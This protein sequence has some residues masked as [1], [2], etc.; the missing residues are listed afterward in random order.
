[1]EGLVSLRIILVSSSPS[2]GVI[3]QSAITIR[4]EGLK[5]FKGLGPVGR[6]LDRANAESPEDL[7]Q[8]RLHVFVVFRDENIQRRNI[9]F[10][11]GLLSPPIGSDSIRFVLGAI[12]I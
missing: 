7:F 11:A 4:G 6:R 5:D 10:D 3:I 9:V 1:M 8:E 2:S 12:E